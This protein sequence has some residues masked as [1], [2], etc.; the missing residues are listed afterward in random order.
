MVLFLWWTDLVQ[1]DQKP[2]SAT[3]QSA[4]QAFVAK[5]GSGLQKELVRLIGVFANDFQQ[6]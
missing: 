4:V 5:K 3:E 1:V 6:Q 2:S